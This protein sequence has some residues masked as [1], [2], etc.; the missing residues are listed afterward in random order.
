MDEIAVL[1][2]NYTYEP[3][4]FTNAKRAITLL[5]AGKAESV[6]AS[7]R[8]IR[9]PSRS[10]HLPAVIRLAAYIRKPFLERVAFNK[11]NILRRDG[12]TCQYCSPA[13]READGG[14]RH[15]ALARA[16]R[17]P[18]PTWS[19]PACACNLL[20]GNRTLEEARLRLIREPVHPQFL[21]SVHL[22]RHPHAT[23]VPRLVAE[24]PGGGP[25]S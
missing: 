7:P 13:R 19:P 6:E 8:V 2:L 11:K 1:V 22:L 4:H 20:K 21:F 17:P 15:A 18:G 10:F 12:Y 14:P 9:S 3:L 16:A 23:L 24:V 5:L 25:A